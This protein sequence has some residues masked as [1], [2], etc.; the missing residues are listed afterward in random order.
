M[1]KSFGQFLLENYDINVENAI[2][3]NRKDAEQNGQSFVSSNTPFPIKK[4]YVPLE[5]YGSVETD[6]ANG[7]TTFYIEGKKSSFYLFS[8]YI[9]K[10]DSNYEQRRKNYESEFGNKS[11]VRIWNGT[12]DMKDAGKII[13]LGGEQSYV[14][15]NYNDPGT[16]KANMAKIYDAMIS[17]DNEKEFQERMKNT[18]IE[19]ANDKDERKH[20][21]E[22]QKKALK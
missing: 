18:G 6:F 16:Y 22:F 9:S 4:V 19:I 1:F 12:S 3:K 14:V 7:V 8:P 11:R 5:G 10:D 15:G 21:K 13:F 20:N 2:F 17:S